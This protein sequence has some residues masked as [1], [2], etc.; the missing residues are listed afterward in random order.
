MRRISM[1]TARSWIALLLVT[2]AAAPAAAQDPDQ[3]ASDS[4]TAKLAAERDKKAADATPPV[5]STIERA[6]YRYDNGAGTPFIFQSWHGFHLAGG[7]FPAGAGLK[8]G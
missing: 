1:S 6:L 4:R 5:R 2:A 8:A 7:S 3:T